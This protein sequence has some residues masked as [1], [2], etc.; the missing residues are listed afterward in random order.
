MK[1]ISLQS[2]SSGNCIYVEAG[3]VR[4]LFDAG[5]T[6]VDAVSLFTAPLAAQ[7]PLGGGVAFDLSGVMFI[8]TANFIDPIPPALLD[9]MEVIRLSGYT[10]EEKLKIGK[11]YI[12]PRQMS[13][14]V[15]KAA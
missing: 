12:L 6:G 7:V 2:G 10:R 14:Q 9:R 3:G 4:L 11:K 15:K 5:I 13:E 8:C 1:V